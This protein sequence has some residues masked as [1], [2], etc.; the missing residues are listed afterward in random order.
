MLAVK[1]VR[2]VCAVLGNAVHSSNSITEMEVNHVMY[3]ILSV[4][5]LGVK[6]ASLDRVVISS[7]NF[8]LIPY[9]FIATIDY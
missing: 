1:R 4:M 3:S 9:R 5:V 2:G 7:I 8:L 6:N